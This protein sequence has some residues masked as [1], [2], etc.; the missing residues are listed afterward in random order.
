MQRLRHRAQFDAVLS[1]AP[2]AKTM[3]FA[4]HLTDSRA[5]GASDGLFPGG[6]RWVGAMVPKRWAR[7]AVTRNLLRRQIYAVA[8]E[9]MHALPE[10]AVVVRLRSGFSREQ[11]PSAGSEALRHAARAELQ[12]LFERA[13]R[14]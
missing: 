10:V 1:S 11:F 4:L 7:R 13:R 9:W 3:H 14:A 12:R 8:R 2:A 6:G 5:R